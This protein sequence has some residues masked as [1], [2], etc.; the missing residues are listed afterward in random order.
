MSKTIVFDQTGDFAAT[1][2][3]EEW[4]KENG[5]SVGT[6]QRGDPRGILKGD[7]DIQ[8][9]RNL[10]AKDRAELDGTLTGDGRNGPVTIRIK[11]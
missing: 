9:W 3:A 8:K 2:A 4:C 1:Y 6:M 11:G 10:N 7:F 5:Y